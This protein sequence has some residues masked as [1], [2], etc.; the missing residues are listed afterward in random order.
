MFLMGIGMWLYD[1][2]ALFQVPEMHE[3]LNSQDSISRIPELKSNELCGSYIY[4]DAYMD[5]DRLVF[6]TLR[7]AH[8]FGAHVANY[9]S[10]IGAEKNESGH[11]VQVKVR[12]EVTKK[13]FLISADHIVSSVG[14]WTDQLGS[15]LIEDWKKILRPTKG[16]HLT[17]KKERLPLQSAVV[18]GAEKGN[19]IVFG[20]PRHEMVIIGTTDTDFKGDPQ[21]VEATN[22]DVEYLIQIVNE[23]FPGAQITK[24]DIIAS[25]A[26]V[27]PLVSDG[28]ENEGKTSR[29]HVIFTRPEGITFVA[30]GKYTTYRLMSEQ[31]VDE[32]LKQLSF[33]E[34]QKFKHCQT[35]LPLNANCTVAKLDEAKMKIDYFSSNFH[36]D[37]QTIKSLVERWGMEIE[38]VLSTYPNYL[39]YWQIEAELAI[40]NTMCLHLDD[41]Y[42]RRVPLFLA[43]QKH[44]IDSIDEVCDIFAQNLKWDQNTMQ[45]E[46]QRYLDF[47]KQDLNWKT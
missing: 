8:D 10:A 35:E 26:G 40:Q 30:G 15:Q 42:R 11:V 19:R 14:P 38:R 6:E 2:L 46:K 31:I 9:V 7:S 21:K 3:R 4:S 29:E 33:E 17:L 43:D 32:V 16:I 28:A 1:A 27:R 23:Y 47:I 18:M 20:I 44:G 34:R 5:D 22:E 37:Q 25:Y 41:F 36:R 39:S 12:D 45:T 24:S 13:E